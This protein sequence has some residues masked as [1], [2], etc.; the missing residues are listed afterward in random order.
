MCNL[1]KKYQVF[2][3]STYKDLREERRAAMEAVLKAGHIPAGMEFFPAGSESQL[4][5]IKRWIDESDIYMLILGGRYG[6][7]SPNGI[8]YIE[9]EYRY[10]LKKN[11][12][13]FVILIDKNELNR[14]VAVDN[15]AKYYPFRE[16]IEK[17]RI[18][19]YFK[20]VKDV[21]LAVYESLHDIERRYALAGW[22]WDINQIGGYKKFKSK[23]RDQNMEYEICKLNQLK[24]GMKLDLTWNTFY[25]G[26]E[27]IKDALARTGGSV[28]PDIIF[29]INQTGIIIASFISHRP[30]PQPSRLGIIQTGMVIS[31][32][33]GSIE[34]NRIQ[35]CFPDTNGTV[36]NSMK[37]KDIKCIAIVDSEIKSG[38]SAKSIIDNI[39]KKY[40]RAEIVYIV[41]TGVIE[42]SEMKKIG[43]RDYISSDDFGWDLKDKKYKPDYIAFYV[44]SPGAESPG[45]MR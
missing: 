26:I 15:P 36:K 25:K 44:E 28:Y 3:S 7:L 38:R 40:S 31:K 32:D 24:K 5:V 9:E 2:I 19:T 14:K 45:L 21:K 8:S 42:T 29:G 39:K 37:D 12:P 10:A 35:Y 41:L 30:V 18:C 27:L 34:R 13:G 1:R 16:E 11:I 43:G 17:T 23:F 6:D 20:D 33:D 4:E 22:K